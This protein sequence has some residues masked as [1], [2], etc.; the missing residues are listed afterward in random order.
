VD[1]DPFVIENVVSAEILEIA[2]A[3]ADERQRFLLAE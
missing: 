3:K 1:N 2:P